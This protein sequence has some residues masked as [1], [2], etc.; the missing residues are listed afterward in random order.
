M[1]KT[2]PHV[3]DIGEGKRGE[4][5]YLGYLLRQASAAHRLRMERA[6]ADKEITLPQFLTLTMLE[7]YPGISNAD[8]A[9]LAMLTPQTVSVIINN[10]ERAGL[11]RRQPHPVHGRIQRIE[12]SESGRRLL[13]QCRAKVNKVEQA[14]MKGL[15]AEEEKVVRRWLV[16]IADDGQS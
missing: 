6:L 3:P 11:V 10:L 1:R 14:L 5:G 4:Q 16:A 13:K 8:L 12:A 15:G 9:R 2:S 7:A